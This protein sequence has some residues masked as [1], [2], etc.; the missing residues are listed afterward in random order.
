MSSDS[1]PAPASSDTAFA[2]PG[3]LDTAQLEAVVRELGDGVTVIG[4]DGRI[5]FANDAA[6]RLLGAESAT[7]LMMASAADLAGRYDMFDAS[8][9][10]LSSDALP[11]RVAFRGQTPPEVLLRFRLRA[12]GEERWSLVRATPQLG[13][14][15]Q[16]ASVINLF[17]DV[18][19]QHR[20]AERLKLLAR[21][22]EILGG[23]LDYQV[24]LSAVAQLAVPALADWC[25]VE[26]V[27]EGQPR[28]VTVTHVD[29]AKVKWAEEINER[30]PPD[31][32]VDSGVYK[33]L[34]TGQPD[35]IN[36]VT[37]E[38]LVMAAKDPDH[39]R[40]LRD[41]GL[42]AALT[43]P[44]TSRG[45]TLGAIVLVTAESGRRFDEADVALALDLGA[46]AGVAVENA[47]LYHRSRE[48]EERLRLALDERDQAREKEHALV[49]E[50][51][52][53]AAAARAERRMA[54]FQEMRAD[55]SSALART[56]GSR[57]TLQACTDAL[58]RHLDA[59]FARIWTVDRAGTHLELQ[60]SSGR[61]TH[62]DGGHA[63]VPIGR[64]KIG[65]IAE[66]RLP[67]L[68]NDVLH[69]PRVGDHAWAAREGMVAFAGYPLL[70]GDRLLGVVAMFATRTLPD[71]TLIALESVAGLLSQGLQ[72]RYAEAELGRRAEDLARS[73]QEL[74][75]F[76]YVASH[77][78]QEP[79]RMV[80]SY[81]Q[82][83]GRRYKDR[84][85]D[86]AREFIGYAVE[87]VT[88]MQ[89]LI[90][91]LLTYSRAGRNV[92]ATNID[93][94]AV[95]GRV[96]VNLQGALEESRGI[97]LHR[98]LP[99]VRGDEGQLVQLFQNL[100]GNALKFRRPGALPVVEVDGLR[101]GAE[102]LFTVKDNG[103]GIEGGYFDRI[104]VIFQRLH[105]REAYPGTGIGLSICKKIVERHGGRI[106][107]ESEPGRGSTF[108]FT[109]P[110]ADDIAAK[111]QVTS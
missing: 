31:P 30:Y 41:L 99:K 77:D 2:A 100:I 91:D 86:D 93:C 72:R 48:N 108:K 101:D 12:G 110:A 9:N 60:A 6:A 7:S 75:Q 54:R 3:H 25:S 61:Y 62:I 40:L 67:H 55:V 49:A 111:E 24:T 94:E 64:F 1:P 66:E 32:T 88:R 87:G 109:L 103:I 58:V 22:G 73:N 43:V 51:A 47:R 39:L 28:R 83:L 106:W 23:S 33:V 17:R 27:E 76:A 13:A 95:L 84:L 102:C 97:L 80:A 52:A 65:L 21:A 20:A 11:T 8:G 82:L 38:M 63:R 104:F 35:L 36:D 68:S 70:A 15:G 57:E 16:V 105:A 42:R 10:A 96:R 89:R 74:E 37:D 69:D 56:A 78:L 59:S 46:R 90:N 14:N 26:V 79:L 5:A 81:T 4:R 71:D 34:R 50:Q 19:D 98:A 29:P 44:L 85:D 45:R 92:V 53:R 107:V 18:T